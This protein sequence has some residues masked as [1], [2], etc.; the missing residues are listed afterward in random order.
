MRETPSK[1]WPIV[2]I[3]IAAGCLWAPQA[4]GAAPS[5]AVEIARSGD[6]HTSARIVPARLDGQKGIA[7]LFEGTDDIHYY[8]RPEAAPAPGFELTVKA[9]SEKFDFDR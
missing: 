4:R 6:Q 3:L 2:S 5:K 9:T 7:V 1:S 8:A